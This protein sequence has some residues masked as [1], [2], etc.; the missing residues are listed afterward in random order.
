MN[1]RDAYDYAA[2][3]ARSLATEGGHLKIGR[4]G[5]TLYYENAQLSGYDCETI[6]QAAVNAGVPVIDSRNA[7]FDLVAKL[8]VLGP[9]IAVNTAPSP[10]PWHGLAYAPLAAVAT[11]YRKAGAEVFNVPS[12]EEQEATFA[13]LAPGPMAVLLDAWLEHIRKHDQ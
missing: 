6:K 7:P 12:D 10:R 1:Q 13:E 5:F 2:D 4:G 8:A 9:M 3:I 11:A